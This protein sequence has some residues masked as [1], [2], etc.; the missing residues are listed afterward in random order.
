MRGLIVKIKSADVAK[1]LGLSK[2]T[3]SLA[4]NGKPGVS[5]QTR[6]KIN[7]YID[8]MKSESSI[9]SNINIKNDAISGTKGMIKVVSIIK[10]LQ[11]S[12][13]SELDFWIPQIEKLARAANKEGYSFGIT[14]VNMYEDDINQVIKECSQ[15]VVAGVILYATEMLDKDYEMFK[16]IS[17]PMVIYDCGMEKAEHHCILPD[18]RQG[19]RI[20]IKHLLNNN[21]RNI[22]YLAND[23]ERY[24]FRERR[25][26]FHE[27]I[28]EHGLKYTSNQMITLGTS[29]GSTYLKM[30]KYL[31]EH[32]LPDAF[33]MENY[34][35]SIGVT[36]ALREKKIIV[37][38]DVSLIGLEEISD[39]FTD[40][41]RLSSIKVTHADYANT[42]ILLLKSEIESESG[43]KYK[44]LTACSL[45]RGESVRGF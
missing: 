36:R 44:L 22:V 40:N 38:N 11:Q 27:T 30:K 35:V 34:Q 15:D 29:I 28:V 18:N 21:H 45:I 37:P 25:S 7:E 32:N 39:Y 26:A 9:N 24:N 41:Y 3:V 42:I 43:L 31:N 23:I 5:Q 13:E 12:H 4:L 10:R 19:V 6:Q 1:A 16:A 14:Y 33:V 8:M 20:A 17:K 2:A